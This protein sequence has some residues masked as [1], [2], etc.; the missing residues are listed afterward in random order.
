MSVNTGL[1]KISAMI[2][3]SMLI[4]VNNTFSCA[5]KKL[6][7]LYQKRSGADVQF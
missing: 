6:T 4:Q 5:C 3:D 7:N 2:N 1:Q